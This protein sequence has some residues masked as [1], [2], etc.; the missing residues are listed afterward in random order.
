MRGKQRM[1]QWA[2]AVI[3][4]GL[5]LGGAAALACQPGDEVTVL[6][7]T[8]RSHY[9]GDPEQHWGHPTASGTDTF[10]IDIPDGYTFYRISIWGEPGDYNSSWLFPSGPAAHSAGPGIITVPWRYGW[11]GKARYTVTA[12]AT[13]EPWQ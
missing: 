7:P 9:D 4:G 3:V 8:T 10:T 2:G 12:T 5:M 13:C 11:F 6:D 1:T